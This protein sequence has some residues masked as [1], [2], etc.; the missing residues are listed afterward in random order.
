MRKKSAMITA[1]DTCTT[2]AVVARHGRDRAR[3]DARGLSLLRRRV[4]VDMQPRHTDLVGALCS[5]TEI[6]DTDFERLLVIDGRAGARTLFGGTAT[7]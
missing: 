7:A 5:T 6:G 2:V 1:I 4:H 3:R